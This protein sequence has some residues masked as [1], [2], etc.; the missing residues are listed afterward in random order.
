[1]DFFQVQWKIEVLRYACVLRIDFVPSYR[2]KP[3][4]H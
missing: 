1:M 3:R 2:S 4:K